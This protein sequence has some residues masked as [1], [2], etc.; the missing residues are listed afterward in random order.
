MQ[1]ID[2]C[3]IPDVNEH[4]KSWAAPGE[5]IKPITIERLIVADDA[6]DSLVDIVRTVSK[7]STGGAGRVMLVCDR[8]AMRRG[9]EDLKALIADRLSKVVPVDVRYVPEESGSFH[10]SIEVAR[11]LKSELKQ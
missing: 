4:L 3:D 1:R 8:T 5:A 2:P 9:G 10:A 11:E 7:P 6:V